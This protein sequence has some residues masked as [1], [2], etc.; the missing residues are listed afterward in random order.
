MASQKNSN[1]LLQ[2]YLAKAQAV[3]AN[4]TNQLSAI[5][6]KLTKLTIA[7]EGDSVVF[8]DIDLLQQIYGNFYAL[9]AGADILDLNKVVAASS[10]GEAIFRKLLKQPAQLSLDIIKSTHALVQDMRTILQ[11][12]AN[13]SEPGGI[14][15]SV[16]P[17]IATTVVTEPV[18]ATT[19]GSAPVTST[20]SK[21]KK[22]KADVIQAAMV[23]D[24]TIT[25][26]EFEEL[27]DQLAQCADEASLSSCMSAVESKSAI[28]AKQPP[29]S[30]P[31]APATTAQ[32]ASVPAT[33]I[34]SAA[35]APTAPGKPVVP[36]ATVSTVAQAASTA[37]VTE[38][39]ANLINLD[40]ETLNKLLT[41]VDA[42]VKASE[43]LTQFSKRLPADDALG[44]AA[45]K[46][47][48]NLHTVSDDLQKHT[49]A[50]YR[51]PVQ[52]LF[53]RLALV[54]NWL[55]SELGKT[56]ILEVYDNG[57]DIEQNLVDS[58]IEPLT[59][60]VRNAVDHGIELPEERVK[61]NKLERAKIIITAKMQ[62]ANLI[63]TIEDNGKGVDLA[64]LKRSALANKVITEDK[65]ATLN[66][67]EVLQLMYA[68]GVSTKDKTSQVSGRGVGMDVVK[69]KLEQ[70]GG[71]I[72]IS[73]KRGVGTKIVVKIPTN[74]KV[75]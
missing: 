5:E 28:T 8:N 39:A 67:Q 45:A 33:P 59:H 20:N 17:D 32:A 58:L 34:A 35:S 31:T 53:A 13:F 57:V 38:A 40:R 62:E 10:A 60:I 74:K 3:L 52:R 51:K 29:T 21:G 14:A 71:T 37:S 36:A 9:K 18:A 70:L 43:D 47:L 68:P 1:K 46:D 49:N 41:T 11:N 42:L 63:I 61:Q 64:A 69:T 23:G 75:T 22:T 24:E 65:A 56:V 30:V 50:L 44:Q 6:A 19:V 54:V 55:N 48:N 26:A 12:N 25:A 7:A 66:D 16:L 73:S 15:K 72:E 27:L 4:I 2:D